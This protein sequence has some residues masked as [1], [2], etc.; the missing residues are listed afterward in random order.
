MLEPTHAHPTIAGSTHARHE[1]KAARQRRHRRC[2]AA[3]AAN[4]PR[5]RADRCV[6]HRQPPG[7]A[8]EPVRVR[9][10]SVA[11]SSGVGARSATEPSQCPQ[12]GPAPVDGPGPPPT[13]WR[14]S[15]MTV[16]TRE[17]PRLVRLRRAQ[18][19][20]DRALLGLGS[21]LPGLLRSQA[22]SRSPHRRRPGQ[23]AA[24]PEPHDRRDLLELPAR[25]LLIIAETISWERWEGT[26]EYTMMAPVRRVSQ[27]LGSTVF[28][29]IWGLI[30][31]AVVLDRARAVLRQSTCR[32]RELPDGARADA[33]SARSASSASA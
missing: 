23:R 32:T 8:T 12:A 13:S 6:R 5:R 14:T 29:I 16:L 21:G 11:R 30:H 15:P 26:L 17:L 22:R 19:Q 2:A 27:L 4:P 20:P 33:S 3:G 18:L 31:T 28:A 10:R 25:R 7:R 24:D 1:R 9:V